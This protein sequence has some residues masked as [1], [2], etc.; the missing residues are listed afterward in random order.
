V[1]AFLKKHW[2]NILFFIFIGLLILPQTRMPI[3]VFVQQIIS[4]SPSEI[5]EDRRKSLT[6]YQWILRDLDSTEINFSRSTGK[7]AI[8]N[9][10]ATWCPPCVAE[11]PSFQKLFDMYDE[12]VD[13]YFV[14][15]EMPVKVKAFMEKEGYSMPVYFPSSETPQQLQYTVLPTTFVISKSGEIVIEEEGA[16]HWNSDKMQVLLRQLVN[17]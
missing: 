9:F 7:V 12:E 2:S 17:N 4:F 8:V 10:W 5:E 14:T 13:F 11:M 16:A 15:S 3:Q 6:D 1:V